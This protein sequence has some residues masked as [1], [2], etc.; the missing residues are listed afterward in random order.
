MVQSLRHKYSLEDLLSCVN[1][2]RK[3]FYYHL[4]RQGIDKYSQVKD[5]IR[6]LYVGSDETYGYR[7]IHVELTK[8]G[9]TY[10]DETIRKLMRQMN[11]MPTCYWTKSG[12]FSSYKGEQGIIKTNI[13]RRDFVKSDGHKARFVVQQ[14][15]SV[16]TTDVTQINLL[17]TKVYLAAIIDLYSKE[18]LAYDIR[19]SPNMHQVNACIDQLLIKLPSNTN[20][21]LHSDQGI[22][23]QLPDYQKR[24]SQNSLTQ[25]MSRKGNCLDN[26]PMES[27]FSLAKREFVWHHVFN[28][29]EDFV[30]RF[31]RYISRFNNIRIARKSE[32]LTP[33]EIRNQALTI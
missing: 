2:N 1:L 22:L 19:T 6:W 12:K 25:S 31:S 5:V 9:Y 3:T 4:Q 27:F 24:L 15:Y 14:P 10:D 26:T 21:I 20:P 28:S 33:V 23:Y 7:R 32:G 16:L 30:Q 29:V 13:V 11:L 18:V 8:L 17:G